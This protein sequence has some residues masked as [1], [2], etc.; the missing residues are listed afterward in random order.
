METIYE[1]EINF[2]EFLSNETIDKKNFKIILPDGHQFLIRNKRIINILDK[3]MVR[4]SF[5]Y[6]T[7][8][9]FVRRQDD[10]KLMYSVKTVICVYPDGTI[11][12]TETFG[13]KFIEDFHFGWLN[14]VNDYLLLDYS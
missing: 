2:L 9:M 7:G 3:I 6:F 8:E 11:I 13:E 4:E 12:T 5:D 14:S 10:V 1:T